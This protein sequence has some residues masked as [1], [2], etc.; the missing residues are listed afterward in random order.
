MKKTKKLV[1]CSMYLA[2]FYVLDVITKLVPILKMPQGGSVGLSVIAILLASYHLGVLDGILVGLMTIFLQY[3]TGD[4]YM[5]G[6]LAFLLDYILAFGI[7][8]IASIFPNFKIGK[9][10]VYTGCL[11]TGTIRWLLHALSGVVC[12]GSTWP[13][14]LAYNTPYMAATT[15][16]SLILLPLIY[17]R[18]KKML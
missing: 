11:L 15:I 4:V 18:L 14:S 7:Y 3:L 10:D 9:M 8:G 17:Q 13:A 1:Y 16:V 2:M 6:Y 12:Y 5:D